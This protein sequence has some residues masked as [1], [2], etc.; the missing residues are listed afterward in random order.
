MTTT[1]A[2]SRHA[3][4][5]LGSGVIHYAMIPV[6]LPERAK[7]FGRDCYMVPDHV[8]TLCGAVLRGD[9][10]VMRDFKKTCRAC[11]HIR[12]TD[13]ASTYPSATTDVDE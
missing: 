5:R 6:G 13:R 10:V 8:V 11:E 2:L 4:R 1:P 3:V 9:I 7:V 12:R